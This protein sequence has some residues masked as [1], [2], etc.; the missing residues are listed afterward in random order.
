MPEHLIFI[1][2]GGA[3][4][5]YIHSEKIAAMIGGKK[6]APKVSHVRFDE[7]S[8]EWFAVLRDGR[9]IAR[10][11][12]RDTVV[13][14]EAGIINGMFARREFIPG[15]FHASPLFQLPENEAM[16]EKRYVG[17]FSTENPSN[18]KTVTFDIYV[19]DKHHAAVTKDGDHVVIVTFDKTDGP[20]T[21]R[22]EHPYEMM[23]LAEAARR[24]G[25]E[26]EIIEKEKQQCRP[27]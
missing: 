24:F 18:G 2:K 20:H 7:H 16:P 22:P 12:N 5:I 6:E 21:R 15:G 23:T 19:G 9:E 11:K 25:I 14:E 8:Q 26:Q 4:K 17:V 1:K 3:E 10:N 27:K 13:Q